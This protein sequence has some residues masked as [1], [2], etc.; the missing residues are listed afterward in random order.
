MS[1]SPIH[2]NYFAAPAPHAAPV[3]TEANGGLR[4]SKIIKP[5][6]HWT[7]Q[8]KL[9]LGT[10]LT[11]A[12]LLA[13][14]GIL[15]IL[16]HLGHNVGPFRLLNAH[17][18]MV[19][20]SLAAFGGGTL[21]VSAIALASAKAIRDHRETN[22]II[23]AFSE[24]TQPDEFERPNIVSVVGNANNGDRVMS[25]SRIRQ[26]HMIFTNGNVYLF[27]TKEGADKL[28]KLLVSKADMVV[29]SDQNLQLSQP[30]IDARRR[31]ED[32]MR[33]KLGTYGYK[34]T[35]RQSQV[36]GG[37][38]VNFSCCGR[39]LFRIP[40]PPLNIPY[41]DVRGINKEIEIQA[42]VPKA[43]VRVVASATLLALSITAI[44][45]PIF[46]QFRMNQMVQMAGI[47]SSSILLY[48]IASGKLLERK[49]SE[50]VTKGHDKYYRRVSNGVRYGLARNALSALMIG[51]LFALCSWQLQRYNISPLYVAAPLLTG[52]VAILAYSHFKGKQEAKR[53]RDGE[54]I[55]LKR[56][57]YWHGA[58]YNTGYPRKLEANLYLA[59]G[60]KIGPIFNRKP[61]NRR[62]VF[63]S[64][65][66]DQ[67][68][69]L[70]IDLANIDNIEEFEGARK[71]FNMS[72]TLLPLLALVLIVSLVGTR[73]FLSRIPPLRIV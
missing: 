34:V 4:Y 33:K 15:S 26:Y 68:K 7:V 32:I 27:A 39:Q 24:R 67:N 2:A 35:W 17:I 12:A 37:Y 62:Y 31:P 10:A 45:V 61:E 23:E 1:E 5:N 20:S 11:V 9:F 16:G 13:S 54:A 8:D 47:G 53:W 42:R 38:D 21:L 49:S 72:S 19:P 14:G 60:Q 55:D 30:R 51:G 28:Q 40:L 57:L 59:I 64:H 65:L 25:R 69:R 73:I 46:I 22:K 29:H 66:L 58:Q 44:V 18:G 50:F 36:A 48:G 56:N 71:H 41:R 70:V 6:D 43:D 63:S 52:S 3:E